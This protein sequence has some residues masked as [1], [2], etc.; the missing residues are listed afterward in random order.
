MDYLTPVVTGALL[1]L[2]SGIQY[3][4]NKGRFDSIERSIEQLRSDILRVALAVGS[5]PEP[6]AG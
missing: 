1:A 3:W 2:F 5:R 4:I 6:H